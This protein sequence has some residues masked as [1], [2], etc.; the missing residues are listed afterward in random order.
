[1]QLS[2]LIAILLLAIVQPQSRDHRVH[3]FANLLS[4]ADRQELE[5]LSH[6]VDQKTTAEIDIVTVKSLDGLPVEAY[7]HELFENWG[8][9]KRKVNNGV[10]L[11]VAPNERRMWITTGYGLEPLLTDARCGEIRD[12]NVIPH[13][14]QQDYAGGI[15]DGAHALAAAILADPAA[16]RGDPNSGP[17]L[18]RTARS[19]A[20]CANYVV[21]A[22][23]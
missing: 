9:G 8:I 4:P 15:K 2:A 3:D 6:N 11:L 22:L 16:A 12:R 1:M 7:A 13:F 21:A 5:K 19:R 23:A 17:I 10:L 20:I 18:A 14:K